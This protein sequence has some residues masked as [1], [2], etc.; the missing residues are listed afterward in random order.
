M[1][2]HGRCL[3][4]L[5][6]VSES[7]LHL[8]LTM[9]GAHPTCD[10]ITFTW[11]WTHM[12]LAHTLGGINHKPQP[13]PHSHLNYCHNSQYSIQQWLGLP[14]IRNT[15]FNPIYPPILYPSPWRSSTAIPQLQMSPPLVVTPVTFTLV[16]EWSGW[17]GLNT[18]WAPGLYFHHIDN[19]T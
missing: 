6:Y 4:G 9:Q 1:Y 17:C 3:Y 7:A 10:V 11:L 19:V 18:Q 14:H 15:C 5:Y 2:I 16:L 12:G 13:P 8:C